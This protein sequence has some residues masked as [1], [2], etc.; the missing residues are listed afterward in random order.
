MRESFLS[1]LATYALAV[2]ICIVLLVYT[3]RLWDADFGVLFA[4]GGDGFQHAVWLKNFVETGSYFSNDRFGAPGGHNLYEF[5]QADGLHYCLMYPI[6]WFTKDV[7]FIVNLYY[8]L[9]FPLTVITSLF[10]LRRLGV[11]S[12]VAIAIANVF[13]FLPFHIMRMGHLFVATY[14][15][16]PLAL[17]MAIRIHRGQPPFAR[18][19]EER[20]WNRRDVLGAGLLSVAIGANGIY[21]AA[22]SCFFY[23]VGAISG[24]MANRSRLPFL[25]GG[26]LIAA[27]FV[28]IVLTLAPAIIYKL[29]APYNPDAIQRVASQSEVYG[30]KITQL[31]LP[32]SDHR[33]SLFRR[34]KEHYNTPST[35]LINE[36]DTAS[37]GLLGTIGFLFLL[38][39]FLFRRPDTASRTL[40]VLS[41]LVLSAL[42]LGTIGGFGAVMSYLLS[43][44]I[45]CYNRISVCIAFLSLAALAILLE[46]LRNRWVNSSRRT[47]IFTAG[48][49]LLLVLGVREETR[50]SPIIDYVGLRIAAEHDR[51]FI[52]EMEAKVPAGKMIYMM[53]YREYPEATAETEPIPFTAYDLLMPLVYSKT[54]HW[55]FGASR[56]QQG[57]LWV[58]R[59]EAM[60]LSERLD[61]LAL[62]GF[63]GIYL[64]RNGFLDRGAGLEKQ[65]QEELGP[66]TVVSRHN[67]YVYYDLQPLIE[68]MRNRYSPDQ[69]DHLQSVV[70][71]PVM[72]H[73]RKGFWLE[74]QHPQNG[75][76]RVSNSRS[77]FELHNPLDFTRNIH[78]EMKFDWLGRT[79]PA[80]LIME[81]EFFSIEILVQPGQ[82]AAIDRWMEVPPGRHMFRFTM[83]AGD[84]SETAKRGTAFRVYRYRCDERP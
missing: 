50:K 21:Y 17:L 15:L 76:G 33:V 2:V 40:D 5:P 63:G 61:Q 59:L 1:K 36:N 47:A 37:L 18:E 74:Q 57:D 71:N 10:A 31:V 56:G 65:L 51:S 25:L 29:K 38:G 35:P 7:S 52:L 83:N 53:P 60:P 16:V 41:L 20:S 39:R 64:D 81:S 73:W 24:A 6:T 27:T 77:E 48:M 45:R 78:L 43:P 68:S 23:F 58:K 28:G 26:G 32:I 62:A 14:Y 75:P 82:G 84:P 42:L 12:V 9:S 79:Q 11:S 22:F 49:L 67:R 34:I 70:L 44:L 30:L 13:T 66:P 8:L 54:L 19:G 46:D 4:Y 80:T 55:T 3:F 69:L 72:I